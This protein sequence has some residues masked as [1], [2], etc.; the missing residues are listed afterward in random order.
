M[1]VIRKKGVSSFFTLRPPNR[2]NFKYDELYTQENPFISEC[3]L[4]T[5]GCE[6]HGEDGSE[7][8]DVPSE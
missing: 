3:E 4:G 7:D 8:D 5:C 1:L 2:R 6:C